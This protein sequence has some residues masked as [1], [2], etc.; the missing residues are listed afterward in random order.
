M[1]RLLILNSSTWRTETRLM[2]TWSRLAA[3]RSKGRRHSS[4][5]ADFTAGALGATGST[6][7]ALQTAVLISLDD[8]ASEHDRVDAGWMGFLLETGKF[9]TRHVARMV[10]DAQG[11]EARGCVGLSGGGPS[12]AMIHR[13]AFIKQ[14]PCS[15]SQSPHVSPSRN[16]MF[17]CARSN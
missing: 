10:Q 2:C 11:Q 5:T 17:R 15:L 16:Q 7:V 6:L 12:D 13:P 1:R 8:T 9:V 4:S 3:T 14:M